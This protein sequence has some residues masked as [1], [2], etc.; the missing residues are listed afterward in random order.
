MNDNFE[1]SKRAWIAFIS[2]DDHL[3]S[4]AD[5]HEKEG[6]LRKAE[7]YNFGWFTGADD[8]HDEII[9]KTSCGF[10]STRRHR[11]TGKVQHHWDER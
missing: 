2:P 1:I 5:A 11:K 3:H 4:V 9:S 10:L 8:H 7:F 6:G